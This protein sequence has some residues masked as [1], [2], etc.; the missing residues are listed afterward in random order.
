M[1]DLLFSQLSTLGSS[2]ILLFGI[3]LLWRKSLHAYAGSFKWQSLALT[4][5]F[6]VIGYFGNEHELYVVAFFLFIL[7]VIDI[8]YLLY[9]M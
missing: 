5:M 6:F 9:C 2:I 8:P 1:N 7:K 3:A 4:V